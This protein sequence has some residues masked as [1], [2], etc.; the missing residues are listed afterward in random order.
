[1]PLRLDSSSGRTKTYFLPSHT[2]TLKS[3]SY[4]SV[5]ERKFSGTLESLS[6][7]TV[8][9]MPFWAEN[10]MDSVGYIFN[11]PTKTIYND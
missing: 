3:L 9:W 10:W 6:S 1:M 5:K 2:P 8:P 11:N 4:G 7:L